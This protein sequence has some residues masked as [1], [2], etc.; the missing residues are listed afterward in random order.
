VLRV[1]DRAMQQLAFGLR[2]ARVGLCQNSLLLVL[3]GVGCE[4]LGPFGERPAA[5]RVDVGPVGEA[6]DALAVADRQA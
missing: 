6:L 5:L 3:Q 2:Q 4:C 1:F